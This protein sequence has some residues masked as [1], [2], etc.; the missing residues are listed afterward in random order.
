[1]PPKLIPRFAF[2]AAGSGSHRDRLHAFEKALLSAGPFAHNLVSV[3]SIVPAGCRFISQDEGFA[4]LSQGEI[5]FCV[6]A[7]QDTNVDGEFASAGIGILQPRDEK[8]FGYISEYHGDAVGIEQTKEI[9]IRLATEMY[10]A[11]M[12]IPDAAR[13]TQRTAYAASMQ[14]AGGNAWVSSVA[15][16]VFIL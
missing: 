15:L 5:T 11:K 10:E 16:C 14:H 8:A 2:C 3:S 1:M 12:N 7:R 9:A 6:M 4:M 13:A